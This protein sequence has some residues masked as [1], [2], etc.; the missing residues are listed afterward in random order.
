MRTPTLVSASTIVTLR[1][2]RCQRHS[3]RR[4][5]PASSTHT[6]SRERNEADHF[7]NP[8]IPSKKHAGQP[9]ALST[10]AFS[11]GSQPATIPIVCGRTPHS[12]T[13]GHLPQPLTARPG[14]SD[15]IFITIPPMHTEIL[16]C[17]P[18]LRPRIILSEGFSFHDPRRS[19]R[20]FVLLPTRILSPNEPPP[21]LLHLLGQNVLLLP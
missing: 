14:S 8:P 10:R 12:K 5:A 2:L 20:N 3:W 16:P 17:L 1:A 21:R 7:T 15:C 6:R 11:L 4:A 9:L 18:D 19:R 13:A